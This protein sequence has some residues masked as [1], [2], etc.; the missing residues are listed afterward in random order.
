ML[1]PEE[2]GLTERPDYELVED[3][4]FPPFPPPASPERD[5]G[6][7][8]GADGPVEE[9]ESTAR[10]PVPPKKTVKRNLPKLDAHRLISEKGL[11]A[12]RHVFDN[13]KFKG[14][15][16]EAEDLRT[17]IRHM[18]HWAHRLFPKL[19]FE[20]FIDRVEYLGNKKEVQMKQRKVTALLHLLLG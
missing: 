17:L 2:S 12:L 3:E 5:G 14:K 9:A 11:P 18:E 13:T 7:D 6:E 4:A 19:Q 20:D 16:H 15:G 1:E 8:A 10:V